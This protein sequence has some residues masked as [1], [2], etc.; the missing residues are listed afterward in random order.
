MPATLP[1]EPN[2][3]VASLTTT[4]RDS[5]VSVKDKIDGSDL[6]LDH[7]T[8]V[9]AHLFISSWTGGHVQPRSDVVA[10]WRAHFTPGQ[11]APT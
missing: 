8:H 2:T 7:A 5:A 11:E 4:E 10:R 6:S 3:P 1:A 9:D